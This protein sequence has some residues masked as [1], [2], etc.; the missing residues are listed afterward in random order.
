MQNAEFIGA[1]FRLSKRAAAKLIELMTLATS[2]TSRP[3][4]PALFWGDDY[5]E[6]K[7]EHVVL[8]LA[9]GWYYLDEVPATLLQE[10][11]GVTLIFAVTSKQAQHFLAK[12]IDY[13]DDRRFFFAP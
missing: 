3:M 9:T 10:V 7:R 12:E 13:Q 6:I 2:S 1:N 5:D 11:D 4:V 8:G